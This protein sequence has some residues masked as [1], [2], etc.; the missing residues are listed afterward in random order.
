M[1]LDSM[2]INTHSLRGDS[3]RQAIGIVRTS[4][5]KQ[6]LS[7]EAQ[8]DM[9][10][11][12]C[13]NQGINLD[14]VFQEDDTS[15]D[16]GLDERC[17]LLNAIEELVK[18]DILV[19]TD[20]S[21]IA[22]DTFNYLMIDRMVKQ[23]GATLCT[24]DGK[25]TG[26][27]DPMDIFTAQLFASIAELERKIIGKRTKIAMAKKKRK[28]EWVGGSVPFGY[29]TELNV[30]GKKILVALDDEQVVVE[31]IKALKTSGLS[32]RRIIDVLDNEG[33]TNREGRAWN[34][35]TIKNIVDYAGA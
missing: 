31:H 22:R 32:L 10:Q 13:D 19:A 29:T 21:R 1:Y 14:E 33:I 18:D 11:E 2:V 9:I 20:I 35:Q 30:D 15:R 12:W 23:K 8:H 26:S 3:M 34:P 4:T 25:Q 28:G 5:D 6:A 16:K 7:I 24:V 27:D 17:I